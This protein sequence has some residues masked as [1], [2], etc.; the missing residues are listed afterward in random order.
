MPTYEI[1]Y[2]E[3]RTR[4]AVVIAPGE[5]KAYDWFHNGSPPWD[6]LE[7]EV[8]EEDGWRYYNEDTTITE[9]KDD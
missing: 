2:T 7:Y 3:T 1:V 5:D 8:V 4:R 9:V 6:E